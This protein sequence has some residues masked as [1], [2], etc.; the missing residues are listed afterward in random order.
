MKHAVHLANC[1]SLTLTLKLTLTQTLAL[2]IIITLTLLQVRCTID[3]I[4]RSLS[5]TV[6]L[7]NWSVAQ[8]IWSNMQLTQVH[9]TI[10]FD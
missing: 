1:A 8:R 3:Q 10:S 9:A 2:I 4:L 6:Q 7:I 5:N